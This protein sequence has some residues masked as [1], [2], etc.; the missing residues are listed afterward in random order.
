MVLHRCAV[1]GQPIAHSLSPVLHNAAYMA[2]GVEDWEYTRAEVGEQ[3]LP[4]F[5]A[6]LDDTW[7]GLSLTMPLK[8]T[9]IPYGKLRNRWARQLKV[10]NTAVM[11]Y[12]ETVR[13]IDLYN[14]DVYGIAC[15]FQHALYEQGTV[16]KRNSTML[17]LGNGNTA[18]SAVAAAVMM[19]CVDQVIVA[20][21][22]VEK[23]E[24]LRELVAVQSNT[25][26]P[27]Q[28]IALS[29]AA[30]AMAQADLIVN[31]IPGLGADVVAQQFME[32]N[33]SAKPDA[34]L[35]DV[36]YAPRVTQLMNAFSQADGTSISGIEMLIY[37]AIAQVLLMTGVDP[38]FNADDVQSG[39]PNVLGMLENAM[40]TALEEALQHE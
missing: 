15:A 29:D 4:A 20:A 25:M 13:S 33:L 28:S 2:L 7:V 30:Q 36:V 5:L 26:K 24:T 10:A 17:I 14:T 11:H 34:L 3:D 32:L 39:Q 22:H 27:L 9:I 12:D 18:A 19:G 38:S 21:R 8:R 16:P 40:R 23:T 1:L 6:G 35:L 37:Q 31:T